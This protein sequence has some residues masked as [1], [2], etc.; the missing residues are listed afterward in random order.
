M[1]LSNFTELDILIDDILDKLLFAMGQ[2]TPN[3]IFQV[4]RSEMIFVFSAYIADDITGQVNPEA[5]MQYVGR[6][7]CEESTRRNRESGD[8]PCIL[9]YEINAEAMTNNVDTYE[10]KVIMGYFHEDDSSS[11]DSID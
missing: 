5:I 2:V 3:N 11:M 9:E 7:M 4:K 10:M 1:I 8:G 6:E